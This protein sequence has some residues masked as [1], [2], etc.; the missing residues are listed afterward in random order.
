MSCCPATEDF[1]LVLQNKTTMHVAGSVQE[2]VVGW[3]LVC[4]AVVDFVSFLMYHFRR[5][6]FPVC[7]RLP[8]VSA[9][10]SLGI[11]AFHVNVSWVLLGSPPCIIWKNVS[12][13]AMYLCIDT[14]TYRTW[15]V[16]CL[17]IRGLEQKQ[18]HHHSERDSYSRFID[19]FLHPKPEQ[20]VAVSVSL[21]L[22]FFVLFW[23]LGFYLAPT[24]LW[25]PEC[26][27]GVIQTMVFVLGILLRLTFLLLIAK[28]YWSMEPD[29]FGLRKEL[30]IILY[31]SLVT[32]LFYF[33]VFIPSLDI[34]DRTIF[35]VFY[36]GVSTCLLFLIITGGVYPSYLSYQL[37]NYQSLEMGM[38]YTSRKEHIYRSEEFEKFVN[39]EFALE[40]SYFFH[41]INR[42]I[43][44]YSQ[45]SDENLSRFSDLLKDAKLLT[46]KYIE[47][48][49]LFQINIDG[50]LRKQMEE[51]LKNSNHPTQENWQALK[52]NFDD[53]LKTVEVMLESDL[54]HR[55]LQTPEGKSFSL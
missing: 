42:F 48:Y 1:T 22:S 55:F 2:T 50:P 8:H 16:L 41:E 26:S 44:T 49:S 28:Y 43:E 21:N 51:C 24:P 45:P 5:K 36:L 47:E 10:S 3:L 11:L 23:V 46:R 34:I 52:H 20:M 33:F 4:Y 12:Y 18:V 40:N 35:P 54:L 38:T 37:K 29:G 30:T 32:V 14:Y 15:A 27:G 25:S 17:H 6:F 39:R 7:G 9:I 19:W 13:F 53:A 31:I